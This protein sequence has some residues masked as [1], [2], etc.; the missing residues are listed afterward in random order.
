MAVTPT[1]GGL[2]G[3][4]L[5]QA[6]GSIG[7]NRM[8]GMLDDVRTR[9]GNMVQEDPEQ[10][11]Y[12]ARRDMFTDPDLF[13]LEMKHIFEGNW[14]Y[15]AHESQLPDNNDY[16]TMWMGRQPVIVSRTRD[17]ELTAVVNACAHRGAMV[18]R[19]KKDNRSTWTCPF[20][21]W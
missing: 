9:L 20:H 6:K 13:D 4:R 8:T 1:G 18:C 14:I 10:G 17:G 16:L 7:R 12:R 2:F 3:D 19:R 11:I 5:D 15:L 21:G